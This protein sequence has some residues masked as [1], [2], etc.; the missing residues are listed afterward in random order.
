[1]KENKYLRHCDKD[2]FGN[3]YF[4]I[5]IIKIYYNNFLSEF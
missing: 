3:I 2:L 5:I 1:M 4:F